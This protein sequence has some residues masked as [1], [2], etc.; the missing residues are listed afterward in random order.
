MTDRTSDRFRFGLGFIA[1]FGLLMRTLYVMVASGKVG[2]DG[3]YCHAVASLVADG[4]GFI[5]PGPYALHGR[6][7]AG[8]P[9]PPAWP[10][11]LTGAALVGL[12]CALSHPTLV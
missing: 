8:P 6:T 11:T 7:V 5:F 3:R 4:K 2:G 1:F 10:L 12:R 9:H